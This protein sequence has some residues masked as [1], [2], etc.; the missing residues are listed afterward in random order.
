MVFSALKTGF[1]LMLRNKRMLFIFYGVNLFFGFLVMLP[2]RGIISSFIG[3]STMGEAL[4]G[5][6]DMNFFFDLIR[7]QGSD[8]GILLVLFLVGLLSYSL[9]NIFLSGGAFSIFI[10][11]GNYDSR[12][13]WGNCGKYFGPFLRLGLSSLLLFGLLLAIVML[14]NSA[15]DSIF[16]D[17]YEYV[18]YW[19]H[20][21]F[22]G[23][24]Y[25][26]ILCVFIIFDYARIQR[27]VTEKNSIRGAINFTF[28]NM[29]RTLTLAFTFT[30]IGVIALLIYNPI[31]DFLSMS[32]WLVIISLLILQQLFIM[33][34]MALK[35]GLYA[36]EVALYQQLSDDFAPEM[37]ATLDT[38]D[39]D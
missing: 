7:E 31:S 23:M 4:G 28:G 3:E 14:L 26:A 39:L 18:G 35:L 27:I 20:W 30:L 15:V 16:E 12:E 25:L 36:S 9:A 29:R 5:M 17:A 8:M 6:F 1:S 22:T 37:A 38:F 11:E 24:R 2:F 21:T 33:F 10:R 13:F 19:T 32:S 34:R